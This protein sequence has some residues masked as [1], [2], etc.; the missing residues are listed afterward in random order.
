MAGVELSGDGEPRA[1]IW[2]GGF[3]WRSDDP[4]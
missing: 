3:T 1:N 2:Q 4:R